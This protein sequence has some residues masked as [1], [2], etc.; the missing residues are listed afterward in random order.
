ML[1][2]G[3]PAAES[4]RRGIGEWIVEVEGVEMTLGKEMMSRVDKLLMIKEMYQGMGAIGG[5]KGVNGNVQGANG[6]AP[7]FSTIIANNCRTSYPP[8][9][10]R[11]YIAGYH[12]MGKGFN[13][14]ELSDLQRKPGEVAISMSWNDFKFS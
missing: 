6:G 8:C 10:L 5:V 3:W 4:Y 7:D 14:G 9:W 11:K 2:S 13:V 12:F 1:I